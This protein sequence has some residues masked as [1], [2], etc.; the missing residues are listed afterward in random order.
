MEEYRREENFEQAYKDLDEEDKNELGE[1][2]GELAGIQKANKEPNIPVKNKKLKKRVAKICLK[3][4]EETPSDKI[5]MMEISYIITGKFIWFNYGDDLDEA[6]E[7]AGELEL[8][9]EHVSED[10]L[11]MWGEMKE[12]FRRYSLSRQ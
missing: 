1:V 12:K 6:I 10:V 11:K 8:P 7:I 4:I 3:L 5:S 9:E 2:S